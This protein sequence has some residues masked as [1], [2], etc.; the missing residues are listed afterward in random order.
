MT[1]PVHVLAL[2]KG[3]QRYVF[4]YDERDVD[5]L[6]EVLTRFATDPELDF[7]WEDAAVLLKRA[8]G[9]KLSQDR[10]PRTG[11]ELPYLH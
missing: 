4:V 11:D 9:G 5:R 8:L 6:L 10:L 1:R 7:T 3:R 2:M